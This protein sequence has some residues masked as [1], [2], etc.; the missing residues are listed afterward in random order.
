MGI[1]VYWGLN[2][3]LFPVAGDDFPQ[4]NSRGLHSHCK[5]SP[6]GVGW[7][8]PK[9]RG[10]SKADPAQLE[11]KRLKRLKEDED[12]PQTWWKRSKGESIVSGHSPSG[13][14]DILVAQFLLWDPWA[15]AKRK[16][17]QPTTRGLRRRR[18]LHR[19][20]LQYDQRIIARVYLRS[21]NVGTRFDGPQHSPRGE[22][23][24]SLTHLLGKCQY[25]WLGI[26][27]NSRWFSQA[28][29]P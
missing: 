16:L 24:S 1:Y 6:L 18:R 10:D 3:H 19:E 25:G 22:E 5:N 17:D 12:Y 4:P 13:K 11:S 28:S 27:S 26:P 21:S 2:S 8:S 14:D 29:V 7:P 15:Y 23:A 20:A 9:R